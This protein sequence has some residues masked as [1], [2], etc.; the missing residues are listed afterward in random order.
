MVGQGDPFKVPS[1]LGCSVI[2]WSF[3]ALCLFPKVTWL[4]DGSR[5]FIL[6]LPL[7]NNKIA[8]KCQHY[9][10]QVLT[11]RT[12]SAMRFSKSNWLGLVFQV[13]S[14]FFFGNAT[15]SPSDWRGRWDLFHHEL[16]LHHPLP[17]INT[18]SKEGKRFVVHTWVSGFLKSCPCWMHCFYTQH[19]ILHEQLLRIQNTN[20]IVS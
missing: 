18:N 10:V 3:Q 8:F 4:L 17:S 19:L 6:C 16:C 9:T 13:F 7:L 20:R 11:L 5:Q 1:N 12:D 14:S 2:L 15:F